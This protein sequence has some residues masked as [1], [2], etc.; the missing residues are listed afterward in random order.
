MI[1]TIK[2]EGFKSFKNQCGLE[3]KG[4]IPVSLV[5]GKNNGGKSNFLKS[6]EFLEVFLSGDIYKFIKS[7]AIIIPNQKLSKLY[8]YKK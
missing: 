6:F 2:L 5:Y 3:L 1:T 7:N 8:R 4:D